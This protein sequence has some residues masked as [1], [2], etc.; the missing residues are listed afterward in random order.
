MDR[1]RL[2]V[3]ESPRLSHDQILELLSSEPSDV[4][5]EDTFAVKDPEFNRLVRELFTKAAADLAKR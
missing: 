1:S 2:F 4:S 3:L 5:D